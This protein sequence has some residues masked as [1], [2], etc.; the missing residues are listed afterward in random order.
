MTYVVARNINYTNVCHYRCR[1]CA[2]SKGKLGANLRC[3]PYDLD[4]GK[5]SG[6]R[7]RRGTAERWRYACRAAFIP[8]PTE[9]H[10]SPSAVRSRKSARRFISTPFR[11]FEVWQGAATF[12]SPCA[13]S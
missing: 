8:K 11:R 7:S 6:A 13:S 3:R 12:D 10:I 5:F 9:R 4:L 1:F 2:F